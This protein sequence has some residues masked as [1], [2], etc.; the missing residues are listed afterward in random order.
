MLNAGNYFTAIPPKTALNHIPAHIQSSK[1]LIERLNNVEAVDLSKKIPISFDIVSFYTNINIDEAIDTMFRYLDKF[2]IDMTGLALHHIKVL[3]DLLLNI[4]I[5]KYGD[6]TY[7][8]TSGLAMGSRVSG[9]SAVIVMDRFEQQHIYQSP[10]F[11]HTAIYVRYIDDTGTLA[12]N[13]AEAKNMLTYL[14]TQHPTIKFELETP[15][16]DGFLPIQDIKFKIGEDG[17]IKRQ[18][19]TKPANKGIS[20]HVHTT[21]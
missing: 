10:M 8:Q 2:N 18:L 17:T 4:I 6:A 7:K 12:N 5:F 20:L 14:N 1:E 16:V 19:Y 13:R 15:Q 21:P 3:Q 11:Q 9:T